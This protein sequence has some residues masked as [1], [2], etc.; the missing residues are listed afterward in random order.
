MN[1][2][3]LHR[4]VKVAPIAMAVFSIVLVAHGVHIVSSGDPGGNTGPN[5]GMIAAGDPGGNTGPN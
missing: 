4:L 5:L 1:T 3:L 2:L